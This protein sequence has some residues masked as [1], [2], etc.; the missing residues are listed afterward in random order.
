MLDS[1]IT[2]DPFMVVGH[3]NHYY[4]FEDYFHLHSNRN[5]AIAEVVAAHTCCFDMVVLA[6]LVLR[7]NHS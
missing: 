2:L 6:D 3:I 1:F 7:F 5:S 4:S